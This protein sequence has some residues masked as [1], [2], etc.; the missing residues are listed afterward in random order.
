MENCFRAHKTST[1]PIFISLNGETYDK[2]IKL[3]LNIVHPFY[4]LINYKDFKKQNK[5][6]YNNEMKK[7]DKKNKELIENFNLQLINKKNEFAAMSDTFKQE[8]FE[9]EQFLKK[10]EKETNS[11]DSYFER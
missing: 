4:S 11:L 1:K 10:K 7:K 6:L 2:D 5:K 9:I 8:I 3:M